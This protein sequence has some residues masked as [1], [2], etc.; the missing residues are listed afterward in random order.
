MVEAIHIPDS[1]LQVKD[2]N[3][4]SKDDVGAL[5]E[6]LEKENMWM[7][8]LAVELAVRYGLTISRILQLTREGS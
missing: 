1:D 5:L 6:Y 2:M 3:V 4:V 7:L 8:R